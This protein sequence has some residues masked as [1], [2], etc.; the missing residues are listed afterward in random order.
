MNELLKTNE[1]EKSWK[2]QKELTLYLLTQII[3]MTADISKKNMEARG[4]NVTYFGCW[5]K[6][7]FNVEFYTQWNYPLEI[8]GKIKILVGKRKLKEFDTLKEWLKKAL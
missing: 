1:R 7:T 8:E 4:S 3:Q 5:K 2:Q 6:I